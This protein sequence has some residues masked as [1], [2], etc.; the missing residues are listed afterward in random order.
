M[1][2]RTFQSEEEHN[3]KLKEKWRDEGQNHR[4]TET[5][6]ARDFEDENWF[7]RINTFKGLINFIDKYGRIIINLSSTWNKDISEIE[8]YDDW[9]E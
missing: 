5:G 8:I 7:I 6:I 2:Q 1:D 4:I 9:R 3:D